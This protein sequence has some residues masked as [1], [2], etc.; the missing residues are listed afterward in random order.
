MRALSQ[1]SADR[2][3]NAVNHVCK[4][5][6]GGKLHGAKR[7]NVRELPLDDPHSPAQKCKS[8]DG[9]GENVYTSYSGVTKSVCR[10][11]EGKGKILPSEKG[12]KNVLQ[13]V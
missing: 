11:C 10:K 5:R 2:C 6:C 12:A 13:S 4:C 1:R 3:E 9:K 7:G 8:C